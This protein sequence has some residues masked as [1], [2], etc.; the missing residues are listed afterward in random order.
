MKYVLGVDVGGTFTDLVAIDEE[1]HTTVIKSPSTPANPGIGALT[2]IEKC[3]ATLDMKLEDFLSNVLRICHGTTVSTNAI[4]TLTGARIGMLIT[5][6]FR[7]ITE[8][9]TGIREN[10]YDY[11]V[12]QPA[13]LAPRYLRVGIEERVRSKGDVHIP[14]NEQQVREAAR[15]LKQQGVEAIAICFLWSF[16]NPAH[17]RRAAE[18][19]REE[20]P[21]AYI[22]TSAEVLSE[23]REYRRFSTT[24]INAYV[25][26]ALAKYVTIP[27]G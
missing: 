1:G 25:G 8:I 23:I 26:P 21:G 2:A 17:E 9:R 22:T 12:P 15:Y 24:C 18:I 19:C 3:A 6:G 11:A 27:D 7:D 4:L 10:R 5:K 16:R 13:P 14:L 20:C